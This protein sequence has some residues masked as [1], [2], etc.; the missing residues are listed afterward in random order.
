[1]LMILASVKADCKI[2]TFRKASEEQYIH[3]RDTAKTS[4]L[5]SRHI[6]LLISILDPLLLMMPRYVLAHNSVP[7]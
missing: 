6:R 5:H 7:V 4:F 3:A 2:A 1:M